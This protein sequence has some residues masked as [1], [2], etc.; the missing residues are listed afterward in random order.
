MISPS[1]RSTTAMPRRDASGHRRRGALV[2]AAVAMALVGA[3]TLHPTVRADDALLAPA[4]ST[5]LD[6]NATTSTTGGTA[7]PGSSTTIASTP[8]ST[9]AATTAAA[10]V[11]APLAVPANVTK[12]AKRLRQVGSLLFP[13]Q[14]TPRCAILDNFGDPRS[15]GRSHEGVD[16]LATLDQE[17]YAVADGVL[18]TQYV[19]GGPNSS[20][21][22]N[23]W[24]LVTSDGTGTY[25]FYAHLSRFADGLVLGATVHQGDLI[26]Y[27]GDTGDPGVGNYHLHFEVHPNGGNAVNGLPLLEVPAGCSIT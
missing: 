20:L 14:T 8:T 27:V 13:M 26:G 2:A 18:K 4:T 15:G 21:S 19:V 17:V 10:A 5:T 1:A 7:I 9:I 23:A 12:P 3:A 25:Y 11:P 24:K 22:G 6:P 16:I